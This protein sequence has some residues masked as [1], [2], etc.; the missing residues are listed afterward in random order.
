MATIVNA[1]YGRAR[2]GLLDALAGLGAL[3]AAA[4]LVGAQAV[5]EYIRDQAGNFA[6][7]PF[8]LDADLALIPDLLVED[9][10]ITEAMESAGYAVTEQPGIYRRN[11]GSQVDLLVP[12]SVGNG[13]RGGARLGVH[14]NRAPRR[15][16]GLEGALVSRRSMTISE[17]APGDPRTYEI[18]VAGPAALLVAKTHKLA[19][20]FDA[21]D[22]KRLSNKDA[23]DI[24]RL[25]RAVDTDELAAEIRFLAGEPI[26]ATVTA[27]AMRRLG[28]LFGTATAVGT[29]L[30]AEH[31]AGV[32]NPD[33]IVASSVAL[34]QA[35]IE[36]MA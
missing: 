22:I 8:V 32:E 10:K 3:R 15:V 5:Y 6:V 11:D 21:N 19:E 26:F 27:E 30:V 12:E 14:G 24:F 33:L 4:V 13:G 16:R 31:V 1:K 9:Q 29:Q 34:S 7:L 23:F 17:F 20:R 28:D 36:S 2:A 35:L 18:S 25:L